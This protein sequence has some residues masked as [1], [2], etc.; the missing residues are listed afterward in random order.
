MKTNKLTCG[1]FMYR[2]KNFWRNIKDIPI[3][4]KRIIFV[5]KH[6]YFP[7]ALWELDEYFIDIMK[8]ILEWYRDDDH[9]IPIFSMEESYEWNKAKWDSILNRMIELLDFMD[10]RNPIYRELCNF[11]DHE[12]M[13]ENAKEEFFKL[14]CEHFNSFWN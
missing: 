11:K 13:K 7:V 8:E 12:A 4:F 6:G 2:S 14:F 1:L 9:S 5:L 10:E 3:F